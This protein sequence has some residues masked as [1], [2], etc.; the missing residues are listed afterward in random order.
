MKQ[1]PGTSKL[2]SLYIQQDLSHSG[3]VFLASPV[4]GSKLTH[5]PS[6][7]VFCAIFMLATHLF[8]LITASFK[9]CLYISV[10]SK[11]MVVF[12]RKLV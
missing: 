3:D 5:P 12:L 6:P 9:S 2:L 10:Q 7:N 8:H 1:V 11:K 4:F